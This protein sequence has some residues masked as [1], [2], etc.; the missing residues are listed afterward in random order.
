M[1]R[2]IRKKGDEFSGKWRFYRPYDQDRGGVAPE[3]WHLSYAP[4]ARQ[5]AQLLTL[6]LLAQQI[7]ATDIALKSVIL[8]HLPE[9]YNRFITVADVS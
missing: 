5:C 9:I 3:P 6:E 7:A 4:L 1:S 2:R 8:A